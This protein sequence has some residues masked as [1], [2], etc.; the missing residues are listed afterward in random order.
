VCGGLEEDSDERGC[1]S[2]K[3]DIASAAEE[4]AEKLA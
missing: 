3:K 1:G 4:F 2:V